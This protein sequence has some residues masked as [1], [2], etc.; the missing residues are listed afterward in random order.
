MVQI[1]ALEYSLNFLTEGNE[2]GNR[3]KRETPIRM[4]VI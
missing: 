4:G 1:F 3:E 2:I